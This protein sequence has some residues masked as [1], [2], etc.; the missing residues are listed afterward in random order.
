MNKLT[1]INNFRFKEYR[2]G[3][4]CI[5]IIDN[6]MKSSAENMSSTEFL[7]FHAKV[8]KISAVL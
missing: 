7:I 1:R 5:F 8:G 4:C 6:V 3:D 2:V